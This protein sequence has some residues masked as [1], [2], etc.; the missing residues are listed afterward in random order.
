MQRLWR[1]FIVL[2]FCLV[3][4]ACSSR[5]VKRVSPPA[6]SIQQITVRTDGSWVVDLRLQNYSTMPMRFDAITL[7]V[8]VGGQSAGTLRAAPGLSI[9]PTSADVASFE[10]RPDSTARIVVAGALAERR[11]L[12]Y[13]VEGKVTATPEEQKPR[14]FDIRYRSQ[15][16]PAPGLE[17]VLR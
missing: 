7:E 5:P 11:A 13:Q 1:P 9:G 10:L 17:G 12:A 2:L 8:T 16:N 15:L 3:F 14:E 4:V 6:A